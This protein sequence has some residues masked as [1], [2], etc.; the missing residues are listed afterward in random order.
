M[1][2]NRKNQ[3]G[4]MEQKIAQ[5]L[6]EQPD[7]R[8]LDEIYTIEQFACWVSNY[9][10]YNC[11]SDVWEANYKH[12]T[13]SKCDELLELG[14][15]DR[16][17]KEG[18]WYA[19]RYLQRLWELIQVSFCDCIRPELARRRAANFFQDP[20]NFFAYLVYE[21]A[22]IGFSSCLHPF[23]TV[24][25]R[26]ESKLYRKVANAIG[27]G[28]LPSEVDSEANP[29]V[30]LVLDVCGKATKNRPIETALRD[31]R[32]A[33]IDLHH[34][35]AKRWWHKRSYRW[36]NG[37]YERGNKDSTYKPLTKLNNRTKIILNDRILL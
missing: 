26:K 11:V 19:A 15:I 9:C 4:L 24:Q 5:V 13:A 36:N 18:V 25:A 23:L 1:M 34:E 2:R 3:Y 31:F 17:F 35:G 20:F 14:L 16:D 29:L 7:P 32:Q 33:A 30:C 21:E 22:R 12:A 37:H 8:L 6:R 10:F 27:D 28:K